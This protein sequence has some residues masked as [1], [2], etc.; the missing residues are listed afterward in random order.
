MLTIS[1]CMIVKNES[2][3]LARCLD[4]FRT[5]ADEIVIVDTGSTDDTKQIAAKYTDQIYDYQ[6]KDDFAD[7]RNFAF[8]KAS[9]DYIYS[10]DADE[11]LDATNLIRFQHLKESLLPEIELVQMKYVNDM[12][13]NTVYNSEKEYRP[14]LFKRMRSFT[15]QSPIHET[16]RLDPVVFDSDIEIL[17]RPLNT[18]AGRDFHT[19]IR[20]LQQGTRL[21]NYVVT[22][23]CK[24]LFISGTS[25][26]FMM[27]KNMF[28]DVLAKEDRP[29][30]ISQ[31][32]SCVLARIY[33]LENKS[34]DFFKI[35]LKD[36]AGGSPCAEICMELGQYFYDKEDYEE[37]V[38]WF[39]NASTETPS[40]L[41]IHT[42]GDKPLKM[43]SACYERLS[44]IARKTGDYEL[45]NTYSYNANEYKKQAEQWKM[46]EEL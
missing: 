25:D 36:M 46:P 33:R 4:S 20:A 21:E 1:L 34:D 42:S 19:F 9:C 18:H 8:S 35:A 26:D 14:K 17:H 41:D 11:I 23:F 24:E 13:F 38:L 32:I 12:Q 43:L 22:M 29:L 40:I 28:T 3:I 16:V 44:M 37:A 7:A 6:W 30:D 2:A 27:C 39:I 5:I 15:W 10:C 45:Y 31:A